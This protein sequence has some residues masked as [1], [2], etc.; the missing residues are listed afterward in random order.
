MARSNLWLDHALQQ[1]GTASLRL[2]EQL[3]G[4]VG[5]RSPDGRG[6]EHFSTAG[7]RRF[8]RLVLLARYPLPERSR[9]LRP[10]NTDEGHS[11]LEEIA[12]GRICREV[13][14]MFN[15]FGSSV[16]G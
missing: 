10:S 4:A 2:R 1:A 6:D 3:I 11:K 8:G 5:D 15:V 16:K 13:A 12:V 7:D 9:Q 14:C